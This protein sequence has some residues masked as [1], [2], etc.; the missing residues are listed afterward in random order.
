MCLLRRPPLVIV[1]PA[2]IPTIKRAG[3]STNAGATH[4]SPPM[5]T[6]PQQTLDICDTRL[7]LIHP[8]VL[9]ITSTRRS[10]LPHL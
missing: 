10:S 8:H 3:P 6:P 2:S 9:S 4:T 7:P 1:L 5:C